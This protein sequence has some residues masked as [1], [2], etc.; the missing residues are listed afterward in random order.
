MRN[1]LTRFVC[2][3]TVTLLMNFGQSR[4]GIIVSN[5]TATVGGTGTIYTP[6]ATGTPQ[7]YAQE[8]TTGSQSVELA[9]GHRSLGRCLGNFHRV[10]GA[11]SG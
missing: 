9:I 5:L 7:A 8:F 11:G 3:C 10:C 4:A 1:V 2:V 6:S